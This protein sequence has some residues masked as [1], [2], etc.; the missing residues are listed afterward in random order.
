[1]AR[2]FLL[3]GL[4]IASGAY[5]SCAASELIREVQADLKKMGFYAGSI[6]GL[7]GSQTAAA[8][9]RYQLSKN[10]KVTGEIN[11]QTLESL[12]IDK[13]PRKDPVPELYVALT[14]ALKG[15]SFSSAP[16]YEQM[17][18][19]RKSQERLMRLKF[20]RG[21]INGLPNPDLSKAVRQW[22][23]AHQLGNSPHLDQSALAALGVMENSSPD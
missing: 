4:I 22:R 11:R 8:I 16:P 9:R 6:D 3:L 15:S 13:I 21:P 14:E 20:Y 10:L 12:G 7:S 17:L 1:M 5:S 18:V 19:I 23:Q 2:F